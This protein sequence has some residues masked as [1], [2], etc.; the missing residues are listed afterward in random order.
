MGEIMIDKMFEEEVFM[1]HTLNTDKIESLE[2]CKKILKFLCEL[3]IKPLPKGIVY[4]G[5]SE[6]EKYFE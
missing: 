5:F 1:N 4:K 6:V 2:D 3:S